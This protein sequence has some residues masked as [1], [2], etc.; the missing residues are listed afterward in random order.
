MK[1]SQQIHNTTLRKVCFSPSVID[2]QTNGQINLMML[3]IAE[4]FCHLKTAKDI[5]WHTI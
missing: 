1:K 4:A 3:A 2:F 5:L